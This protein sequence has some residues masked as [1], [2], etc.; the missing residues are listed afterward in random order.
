MSH[1]T[2]PCFH[3]IRFLTCETKSS[4]CHGIFM[5]RFVIFLMSA[6]TL[7]HAAVYL[8]RSRMEIWGKLH[9]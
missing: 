1:V 4:G 8:H 6:K 9:V 3:S 2:V 5:T 7:V